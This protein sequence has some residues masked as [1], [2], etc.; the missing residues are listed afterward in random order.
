MADTSAAALCEQARKA[1]RRGDSQQAIRLFEQALEQEETSVEA[2]E[3]LATAAFLVGN[4]ALAVEH[5]QRI[6]RLQ[7]MQGKAYINLGAVYN[8]LQEYDKAIQALRRGL[9]KNAR[10]AEGYYNLG[11]AYRGLEQLSLAASAY[12]EAIRLDPEM[13]EAH[14]NLANV[15]LRMGNHQQA[16]VH[17]R[18]ALE[19]RPGF[20]RAQR[21]LEKAQQ[22]IEQARRAISPFGRLVDET[23]A[24][25]KTV[26]APVREL[27]DAERIHDR[28]EVYRITVE[29][30][31]LTR[32][33][34]SHLREKLEPA[35][36]D[37]T[38]ATVGGP[39]G[40]IAVDEAFEEFRRA[41]A[42]FQ[43]LRANVK[44]K[45]LELRAHEELINTPD[46]NV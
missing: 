22:A 8:R 45:I 7:P 39:G 26:T 31:Q 43:R 6:T 42:E 14:Q 1:L 15:Y 24:T 17:F 9:Q 19:I 33:F 36:L 44:R 32:E 40:K 18:K 35:L 28:R 5:F 10:L 38:R 13:A 12:R 21:G 2:H 11:I 29:I 23:S 20:V 34:V 4:Y 37:L 30:T 16:V 27:S 41:V 46:L 3:G 25:P